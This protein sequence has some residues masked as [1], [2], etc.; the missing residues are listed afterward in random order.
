MEKLMI[1]RK[2]ILIGI[3]FI[4]I[5]IQYI[6]S[7][8]GQEKIARA[9]NVL[10]KEPF[11]WKRLEQ[12]GAVIFVPSDVPLKR[13]P[14]FLAILPG[15]DLESDF[16][17]WFDA[18][19][20]SAQSGLKVTKGGQV[21]ASNTEEGYQILYTALVAND[22]NGLPTYRFYLAAH[23][24]N[25]AEMIAF[26]A[27]D[28]DSYRRYQPV[29]EEFL[30]SVDFV[31]RHTQP[32]TPNK[33]NKEAEPER[34]PPA[35]N[36]P[37]LEGLFVGTESRQQ[38]NPVTKYYDYIVRQVYYLF[39]PDGRVYYGLPK[40][41]ALSNFEFRRVQD[42]DPKN[43]GQYQVLNNQILFNWPD[44]RNNTPLNFTRRDQE[45]IQL[46]RTVYYRVARFDGLKL[47]G[48]YSVKSFTNT[49]AGGSVG[50]VSGERAI[51]FSSNGQFEEQGFVGF[52]GSTS[53]VGSATSSRSSG[54]GTYRIVG[55]T[56][57]LNY[58]DGRRGR[59]TFFVYP[60]NVKE[61]R[62]GLIVIDG[63]SFLLR[64]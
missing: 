42:E 38:F 19:L 13:A 47:E 45:S 48:I 54:S 6:G 4:I 23:P 41:G 35:S 59:F 30:K 34:K 52:A 21:S 36:S 28:E 61:P 17:E 29:L 63:V 14:C 57:E 58:S 10:F 32:P 49:S 64:K 33:E 50:G 7:I 43:C 8:Y 37:S 5:Q 26:V 16:R 51:T 1:G 56:L 39:L 12:D 53:N 11:G 9:G 25:R 3:L 46:G 20:Q 60:E 40:G 24:G 55:N 15:Q 31:N 44:G 18:V 2:V 27:T 62:P 22:E